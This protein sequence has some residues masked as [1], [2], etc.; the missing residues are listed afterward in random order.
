MQNIWN[1]DIMPLYPFK[2]LLPLC[3]L[4]V[5]SSKKNFL[6]YKYEASSYYNKQGSTK[7]AI[8]INIIFEKDY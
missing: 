3:K 7:V 6:L 2:V 8:N 4:I 5:H 1:Y